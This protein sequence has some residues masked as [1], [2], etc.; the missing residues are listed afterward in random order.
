MSTNRSSL[1]KILSNKTFYGHSLPNAVGAIVECPF[2]EFVPGRMGDYFRGGAKAILLDDPRVADIWYQLLAPG[3][4]A[5]PSNCGSL[6]SHNDSLHDIAQ[7]HFVGDI[8]V[9]DM[10]RFIPGGIGHIARKM[11]L[12]RTDNG[13]IKTIPS[14]FSKVFIPQDLLKNIWELMTDVLRSTFPAHSDLPSYVVTIELLK[15]PSSFAEVEKIAALLSDTCG[16]WTR[17]GMKMDIWKME[18]V[19]IFNIPYLRDCTALASLIPGLRDVLRQFNKWMIP[20]SHKCVQRGTR[21]IGSPHCDGSKILSALLSERETISTE[22]HTG[23]QW[24]TLPL[25][26][27]RL[28]IIP[29]KEIDPHLGIVPTWHRVLVQENSPGEQPVGQGGKRNITL[30]LTVCPGRLAASRLRNFMV[31]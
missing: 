30:S 8:N 17:L 10:L 20:F 19:G 23:Q 15:Y 29:A 9:G 1:E 24:L 18:A 21:I 7:N 13:A 2:K 6:F 3:P 25:S 16:A 28:T 27:D 11:M 31:N 12:I 22:I 4:N 14:H 5:V 26:P